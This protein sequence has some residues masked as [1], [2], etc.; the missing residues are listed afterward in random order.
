MENKRVDIK[1]TIVPSFADRPPLPARVV[2]AGP[3]VIMK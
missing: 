1:A 3:K 2:V